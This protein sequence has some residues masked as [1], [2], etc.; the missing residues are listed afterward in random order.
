MAA[1]TAACLFLLFLLPSRS[2]ALALPPRAFCSQAGIPRVSRASNRSMLDSVAMAARLRI[3]AGVIARGKPTTKTLRLIAPWSQKLGSRLLS[4]MLSA[5][6]SPASPSPK[7]VLQRCTNWMLAV[8]CS[9]L[10]WFKQIFHL[11]SHAGDGTE[12]K[13]LQEAQAATVLGL[14]KN[15][16]LTLSKG[17]IGFTANSQVASDFD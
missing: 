9:K 8:V 16:V 11:V 15:L 12:N 6:A 14:C 4:P 13:K 2:A 17:I 5:S 10:Y 3:D 1:R 7:G